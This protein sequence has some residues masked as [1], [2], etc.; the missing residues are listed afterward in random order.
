[1]TD[2]QLTSINTA[3]KELENN[4]Y[5]RLFPDMIAPL[6]DLAVEET[7]SADEHAENL[8]N[9]KNALE[10]LLVVTHVPAPN[11]K[12]EKYD[13]QMRGYLKKVVKYLAALLDETDQTLTDKAAHSRLV[14]SWVA[15]A[16]PPKP[17]AK[18]RPEFIRPS[19]KSAIK[20]C[21]ALGL[22][23]V[24]DE[25]LISVLMSRLPSEA[26]RFSQPFH[27]RTPQDLVYL[28]ALNNHM[29][30][31]DAK[32]L[33]KRLGA[34]G[35]LT[36]GPE[37]EV[38]HFSDQTDDRP[39]EEP[40]YTDIIF[41]EVLELSSEEQLEEYL[42][43][44]QQELGN[45]HNR[46]YVMFRSMIKDLC[47]NHAKEEDEQTVLKND[48]QDIAHEQVMELLDEKK[49]PADRWKKEATKRVMKLLDR[50]DELRE[51][52][53]EDGKKQTDAL[54]TKV[55][56]D[57]ETD[58]YSSTYDIETRYLTLCAEWI[59]NFYLHSISKSSKDQAGSHALTQMVNALW[60]TRKELR[61]IIRRKQ[62]VPRAV[63][64]LMFLASCYVV[65]ELD[66]F[67]Y[68]TQAISVPEEAIPYPQGSAKNHVY[69]SMYA[70]L[71]KLLKSSGFAPMDPQHP[72]DWLILY[73]LA[74]DD[75]PNQTEGSG[76]DDT[77]EKMEDVY[78]NKTFQSFLETLASSPSDAS[79]P[80]NIPPC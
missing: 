66:E 24:K 44:N 67:N 20:L 69:R 12:P 10:N 74:A 21:F 4:A 22:S 16:K 41:E 35:L 77:T 73:C 31:T 36:G 48:L 75:N 2:R 62:D 70:K 1:M 14:N 71:H 55:K 61:E 6:L 34:K 3:I 15:Y 54:K 78:I 30:F 47:K 59:M 38:Y 17:G 68:F 51:F 46:A 37:L 13:D 8:K 9:L 42:R 52:F 80:Q 65:E 56:K 79:S 11:E 32:A 63:L 28:Y 5:V 19:R 29:T 60:P 27:W 18:T 72:F 53:Y 64:V 57:L 33:S 23:P 49:L 7:D 45:Y 43:E 50:I 40:K 39:R 25:Y 58:P 26:T 76:P